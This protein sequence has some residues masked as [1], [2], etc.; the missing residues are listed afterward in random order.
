MKLQIQTSGLSESL[1]FCCNKLSL[2]YSLTFPLQFWWFC[3]KIIYH[4][5]KM[6]NNGEYKKWGW[7]H[8]DSPMT[9]WRVGGGKSSSSARSEALRGGHG[10]GKCW[11]EIGWTI[12]AKKKFVSN[13]SIMG[14]NP[15]NKPNW[16]LCQGETAVKRM[17]TGGETNFID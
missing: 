4:Q 2:T 3:L 6:V 14:N 9:G 5:K 17:K 12:R 10:E 11:R 16:G 15:S 7:S 13:P 8:L 1:W